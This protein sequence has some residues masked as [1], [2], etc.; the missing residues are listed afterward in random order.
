M[1]SRQEGR[2]MRFGR[3]IPGIAVGLV[4]GT[5]GLGTAV[6]AGLIT[7][8]DIKNRTIRGVDLTE[9]LLDRLSQPGPQGE[10]GETGAMGPAGPAGPAGPEGQAGP[11]GPA[12]PQG[13]MGP[14]G[15]SGANGVSG[16][17]VVQFTYTPAQPGLFE[18]TAPCPEGKRPTGGGYRND[19]PNPEQSTVEVRNSFPTANGWTIRGGASNPVTVY[20][21]CAFV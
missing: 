12:G 11:T 18:A 21:I 8:K 19:E 20:A 3:F 17:E 4:V 7:S 16:Y 2:T 6:A 15:S 13:P 5:L 10:Q 9:N 1:G 14:A